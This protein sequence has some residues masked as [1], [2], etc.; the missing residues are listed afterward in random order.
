MG[1]QYV[2]PYAEEIG[3][4]EGYAVAVID[5]QEPP[6]SWIHHEG[7]DGYLVAACDCGH[8]GNQWRGTGRYPLTDAGEDQA[9]AEWDHEHLQTLID[10]AASQWPA[11]A[12]RSGRAV[13][14]AASAIAA[15]KYADAAEILGRLSADV[16]YRSRMAS[17]LAEH[18]EH[19]AREPR[20]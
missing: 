15:G 16:T 8:D 2:G 10:K 7:E 14:E 4:H 12:D 1:T 5:G 13:Q 3:Y 9:L 17:E 11:W 6:H 18:A 19:R 20:L